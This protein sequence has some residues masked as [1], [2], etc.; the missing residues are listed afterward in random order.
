MRLLLGQLKKISDFAQTIKEGTTKEI[1]HR[2][3]ARLHTRYSFQDEDAVLRLGNCNPPWRI[4]NL[5]YSGF[6]AFAIHPQAGPQS[7]D[8]D[9]P[10]TLSIMGIQHE[11]R[12]SKV[13]IREQSKRV[14]FIGAEFQHHRPETLIFLR[15]SLEPLRWGHSIKVI[16]RELRQERY[17]AIE[18][19]CL[20]GEGPTD[21]IYQVAPVQGDLKTIP[22]NGH[23]LV[24]ALLTFPLAGQYSEVKWASNILTTSISTQT[25][26]SLNLRDGHIMKRL[27]QFNSD[28]LRSGLC[29]LLGLSKIQQLTLAPLIHELRRLIQMESLRDYEETPVNL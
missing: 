19:E 21:L 20:R 4:D 22:A 11:C 25:T 15:K 17:Q 13:H 5:S 2:A 16:P 3:D 23:H 6:G 7:I 24:S 12:A 14:V 18:W 27:H 10:L 26:D 1:K 28:Q 9:F 29:I 8:N